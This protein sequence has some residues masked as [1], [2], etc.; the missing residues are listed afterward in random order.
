MFLI[1]DS[2]ETFRAIKR[3]EWCVVMGGHDYQAQN[4]TP[5]EALDHS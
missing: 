1:A 3:V 2:T 4:P 5:P